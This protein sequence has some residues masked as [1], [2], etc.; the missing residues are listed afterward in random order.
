MQRVRSE[1]SILGTYE[2]GVQAIRAFMDFAPKTL[3]SFTFNPHTGK[4]VLVIDGVVPLQELWREPKNVNI[5]IR[6]CFYLCY[7][8][9]PTLQCVRVGNTHVFE[10]EGHS[11]GKGVMQAK[12][13]VKLTNHTH[14][15]FPSVIKETRFYNTPSVANM[16]FTMVNKF[17]PQEVSDRHKV[18]CKFSGGRLSNFYMV[19]TPEEASQ[20]TFLNICIGLKIRMESEKAFSLDDFKPPAK[21]GSETLGNPERLLCWYSVENK[22]RVENEKRTKTTN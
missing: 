15:A 18:G 5:T 9:F 4:S 17:I 1:Y 21:E 6:G 10:L 14:G 22:E 8:T 16:F 20:R 3:M 11:W 13:F 12:N 19:P 7:A 2:D